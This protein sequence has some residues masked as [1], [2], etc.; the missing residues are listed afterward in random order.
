MGNEGGGNRG[1]LDGVAAIAGLRR[2]TPNAERR[3]VNG[4]RVNQSA[5]QNVDC[6]MSLWIMGA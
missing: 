6:L 4:E 5:F 1:V 2:R 3:T